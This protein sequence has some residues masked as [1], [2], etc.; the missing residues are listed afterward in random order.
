VTDLHQLQFYATPEH[1][2]SYLENRQAKTIF[3]DP[4]VKLDQNSY[5]QLSELGFRR[6]GNHVYRPHCDHCSACVSARIPVELFRPGRGQKRVL[7]LNRD[8][9]VSSHT[10]TYTDEYYALYERYISARHHDGDMFPASQQQFESFLVQ[11]DYQTRFIEYRHNQTLLAVSVV[12]YLEQGLSAIYTFFEPDQPRRSL[13]K[14][15]ILTLIQQARSENLPY[16]YLGYW[17]HGC[18]K[19]AYKIDYQPIQL[20]IDGHWVHLPKGGLKQINAENI[21]RRT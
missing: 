13:G 15:A 14:L 1:S 4:G 6:S 9:Q 5:S 12:D 18:Q 16:L 17:V 11:S 2:C 21:L 3:V 8:L 20:L 10:P 7:K 19:M